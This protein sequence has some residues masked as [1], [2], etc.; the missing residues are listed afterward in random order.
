MGAIG[1]ILS[2]AAFMTAFYMG[3]MMIYTFFG[4]NRTGERERGHLHEGDW[5]LTLPLMVL[6][7]LAVVGGFLNVEPRDAARG[8]V[9]LRRRARRC[10]TGCTRCWPAATT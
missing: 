1:V 10:T 4:E 9:R 3:R 8:A 7:L 5:T 2:I 6:G